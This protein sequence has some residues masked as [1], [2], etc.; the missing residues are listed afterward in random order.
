MLLALAM[1]PLNAGASWDRQLLQEWR[2]WRR[3]SLAV[4]AALVLL[5]PSFLR[6]TAENL[7]KYVS[8]RNGCVGIYIGDSALS[9]SL[10]NW[11]YLLPEKELIREAEAPWRKGF[12]IQLPV[13]RREHFLNEQR[14]TRY[15]YTKTFRQWVNRVQDPVSQA[16]GLFLDSKASQ[17]ELL[18]AQAKFPAVDTK[19]LASFLG[20]HSRTIQNRRKYLL[21]H[22]LVSRVPRMWG[23]HTIT[24][25]GMELLALLS[26]VGPEKMNAFLG[27]PTNTGL[28]IYQKEHTKAIFTFM[29]QLADEGILDSWDMLNA[30]MEFGEIQMNFGPVRKRVV[31]QPDSVGILKVSQRLRFLFWLEIDRGTRFGQNLIRQLRKYFLV[32]Y[33]REYDLPPAPILYVIADKNGKDAQRLDLIRRR[34][35]E[36]SREYPGVPLRILLTTSERIQETEKTSIRDAKIWQVFYRGSCSRACVALRAGLE[37]G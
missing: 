16:A 26:G 4:P 32:Q 30:R 23:H 8:E 14:K 17:L 9:V 3:R 5:R 6:G 19:T 28:L 15:R 22:G 11:V 29:Q 35:L 2:H 1:E 34:L 37:N 10:P 18:R 36:I 27:D 7:R 13:L 20:I 33:A 24:Q 12:G 25:R 31:V 21:E